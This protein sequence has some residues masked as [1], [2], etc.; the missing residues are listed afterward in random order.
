M[1]AISRN[2]VDIVISDDIF[3]RMNIQAMVQ[4]GD[5]GM[6]WDEKGYG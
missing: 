6:G 3:I 2:V 5:L 1:N 4:R